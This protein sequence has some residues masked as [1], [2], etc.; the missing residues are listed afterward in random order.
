MDPNE[1]PEWFLPGVGE[2][3]GRKARGTEGCEGE[4]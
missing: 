4:R 3:K 2:G 1:K